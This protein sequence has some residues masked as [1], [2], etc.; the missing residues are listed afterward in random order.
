VTSLL[1]LVLRATLPFSDLDD[2]YGRLTSAWSGVA[3]EAW[4]KEAYKFMLCVWGL[5]SGGR[6]SFSMIAWQMVR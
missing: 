6:M 2:A 4:F 5:S 3:Y 1:E